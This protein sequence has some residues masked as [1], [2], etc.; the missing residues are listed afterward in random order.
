IEPAAVAAALPRK[1]DRTAG[2]RVRPD[3][4]RGDARRQR[5]FLHA[6]LRARAA[7]NGKENGGCKRAA[8][9]R[10]LATLASKP[11]TRRK[12]ASREALG[13]SRAEFATLRRLRTPE[14]IQA[15]L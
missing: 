12:K 2:R 15:F 5:I 6:H 3:V 14:K 10:I 7:G 13:L 11:M 1:P 4:V 8:H 9:G